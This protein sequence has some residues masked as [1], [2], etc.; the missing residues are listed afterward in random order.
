MPGRKTKHGLL[1]AAL[2]C[3]LTGEHGC[4]GLGPGACLGLADW[5]VEPSL[6]DVN[7][8]VSQEPSTLCGLRVEVLGVQ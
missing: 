6:C 1:D 3:K 7:G 2:G 5:S 4:F 8:L